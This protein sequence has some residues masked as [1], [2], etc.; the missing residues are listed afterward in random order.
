MIPSKAEMLYDYSIAGGVVKN[1]KLHHVALV[2]NNLQRAI[3]FYR[4]VLQLEQVARPAFKSEGA[5]MFSGSLEV[6]LILHPEGTFRGNR[7]IDIVDA[8]FAIRVDDFEAAMRQLA[9]NGFREDAGED[10]PMRVL[11]I[12]KG[13]AGFPQAY[14]LD[15]DRNIVEINAAG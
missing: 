15:P 9:A 2:T 3:A 11:V 13:L 10:D 6:H 14:I 5:W 8:H 7:Q 4:D 1:A 12:R